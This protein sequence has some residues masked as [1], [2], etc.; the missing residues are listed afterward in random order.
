VHPLHVK[1]FRELRRLWAQAAAI[2]L[3][4]AAGVATLII[5]IGTYQSLAQTRAYYYESNRFADI[6]ASVSRAPRSVLRQLAEI[7]G[8]LAADGRI[9]RVALADI[10]GMPEP[11]SV[12]LVSLPERGEGDLNRLYM[13]SGRLPESGHGV[14]AVVS[15]IF[16]RANHFVPGSHLGVILNGAMREI[17]VAGIALS[18]EYIYAMAP[19]EVMPNE[20][21]F[22]VLWVPERE[23]AAAYDLQGAFNSVSL[24]LVPGAPQDAVIAEVDRILAPYGG[25]GAYPRKQ[26]TS[27]AFLDSELAQ[28]RSMSAVLPPVFLLV[29]AF[30]VNMTLTRLIALEREQ[31]GLLKAL[32]YSSWSIA[33]H[34]IEFVL[35]IGILGAALG[36]V[37]GI[38]AG[39]QL[40]LLYARFYSFPM[41]LFS[42]DPSLYL[43]AGTVTLGAATAGALRAA[44]QAASLPPAV[45][46]LPPAPADYR[47]L[48][49][50]RNP[51]HLPM[52]QT[53]KMVSRHLL[54]W[55]WRT[56]GAVVGM[57]FSVAILVG[58]LWSVGAMAFMVDYTFN[59][60]ERQ[61][62][63]LSF[64]GPR[65]SSALFEAQRLPGVLAAEPVQ[66]I[67]V[68][69]SS[70]HL[71][72]RIAISGRSRDTTLTRLLDANLTPSPI[73]ESGILLSQTLADIL[74][75]RAGDAVEVRQLDGG[76]PARSVLVAGTIEGYLGLSAYMDI[77]VLRRLFGAG[78]TI[79]AVNIAID[80]TRQAELFALLKA[81]PTIGH[82]TLQ[83]IAL[84][85][86]RATMAQNML[87]MIGVLAGLA[88][89]IAFG[90]VYNFARISLSEQGREMASLR[91]LG[92]TRTEVSGLLLTEIAVVTLLSQPLGWLTGWL[93]AI[94]MVRGFSS[95][96]FTMPLIVEPAVY[97]Y[98][99]AVV[100]AAAAL[101]G[102]VVRARIDRLDMIAVLKTRE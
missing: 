50:G 13:R 22:G 77:D 93:L 53:S 82:I 11:A 20:G 4:M 25:V 45:A 86:F 54:H 56:L 55:P 34:Y 94:G 24:R 60:T 12:L 43:I 16:A 87:V 71:S 72:R 83:S 51:I 7:D 84:E 2:A 88:G 8:V 28:L 14:E 15:E 39:S 44:W 98:S 91:V 3:V 79:S 33:W 40:T 76:K 69:I 68:E 92:F 70:G 58:S 37:I 63:S 32:G 29:A 96:L 42:R 99:S 1:L 18:P 35:L 89:I 38:W 81:T 75:V 19:G 74:K 78:N 27:H 102:L 23:L 97:V 9:T 64:V 36:Y 41:L 49:G 65:P 100:I 46:M 6:F 57:S 66:T 30:L 10:E 31:I 61:D 47:R 90:V 26:Q 21:R 17:A 52:R 95:E 80:P 62:A 73:P 85:R 67:A 101:S 5:G 59:R 48:L